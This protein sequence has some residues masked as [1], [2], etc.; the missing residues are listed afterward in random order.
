MTELSIYKESKAIIMKSG[1]VHWVT[2]E[3]GE[4]VANHLGAQEAHGF[5]K[6]TELGITINSA[7]IEGV[8]GHEQYE[9]QVR[10]KEGQWQC[11][12]RRWHLKKG[13][14]RC[15]IEIAREEAQKRERDARAQEKPPTPEERAAHQEALKRMS[16]E[17]ALKGGFL[18]Q[19]YLKG[20]K[21]DR[22]IRRS[23]IRRWEAEHG[24][25]KGIEE[26]AIDEEN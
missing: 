11:A 14:C 8:Y 23:T 3:T 6:I 18:W 26:L 21:T 7:E 5:L 25:V 13:E 15:K 22:K 9:D 10:V 2:K 12:Y 1:L 4:K 20:N 24:E 19:L 17:G 16:E